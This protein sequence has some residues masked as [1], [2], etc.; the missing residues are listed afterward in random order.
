[1]ETGKII[2]MANQKGG[3]GKDQQHPES[4][5]LPGGAG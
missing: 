2:V 5:L 4:G 3:R 1:M